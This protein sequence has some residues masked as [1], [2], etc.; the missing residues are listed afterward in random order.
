MK[1]MNRFILA[2]LL[3]AACLLAFSVCTNAEELSEKAS[4]VGTFPSYVLGNPEMDMQQVLDEKISPGEVDASYHFMI[5]WPP[6]SY[7]YDTSVFLVEYNVSPKYWEELSNPN[8]QGIID[9]LDPGYPT[10]YVP[11]FGEVADLN[12]N[13]Q[14]RVIGHIKVSYNF[15][16][17]DYTARLAPYNTTNS[18]F[19]DG[20]A[21]EFYEKISNYLEQSNTKPEQVLMI[22]HPNSLSVGKEI[23]AVIKTEDDTVI[24]DLSD[25]LHLSDSM[26]PSAVAYTVEEYRTRRLEVE[27]ELYQTVGSWE[28]IVAG[29]SSASGQNKPIAIDVDQWAWIPF[30]LLGV[31]T[32]GAVVVVLF[33][34][35]KFRR[36]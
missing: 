24:L 3:I 34:R 18:D 10:V 32:V 15:F 6:N 8:Y 20:T 2:S 36:Q 1:K 5:T 16:E 26:S 9:S 7:T 13:M 19:S 35:V 4:S 23:I 30:V 21:Y 25:S 14:E 17:N 29:G 27:K 31:A 28:E 33:K 11:L 22:R 12:G